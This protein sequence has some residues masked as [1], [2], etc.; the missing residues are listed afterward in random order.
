MVNVNKDNALGKLSDKPGF[1]F[2]HLLWGEPERDTNQVPPHCGY[3]IQM[4]EGCPGT[5]DSRG[6]GDGVPGDFVFVP[7]SVLQSM[8]SAPGQI[9][10]HTGQFIILNSSA[11]IAQ[12]SI[13]IP[14]N[15][16]NPLPTDHFER[17]LMAI[18]VADVA[19]YCRLMH[20]DETGTVGCLNRYK[21]ILAGEIDA[22]RG[23]V[24]DSCGDNL[25]AA[26]LS[27][28]KAVECAA[29]IQG[30]IETENT[31]RTRKMFFRIGVHLGDVICRESRLYGDTVNIA[32]RLQGI[33][34]PGGIRI[35]RAVHEQVVHKLN[36]D[37]CRL[38]ER[39]VKNIPHPIVVYRVG[40]I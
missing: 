13:L 20:A 24:V 36:L 29:A 3:K 8:V 10:T 2:S 18:L 19:G 5:H 11:K 30:R 38:G 7:L 25:M 1:E 27:A 39:Y 32:A 14:E 16:D 34:E 35:S 37:F 33:S 9:R 28:V 17:R 22:N 6:Q 12:E 4:A 23:I 15:G 26:F 21:N 31:G 40:S